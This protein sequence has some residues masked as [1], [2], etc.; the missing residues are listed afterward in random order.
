MNNKSKVIVN[1]LPQYHVIP[2]NNRWWG[3]GFTDWVAVKKSY[4]LYS[5]HYQPRIPLNGNYYSL[6]NVDTIRWQADLANEYGIYGFG[7]YHYWFSSKMQLLQKPA[8]IIRDTYDININYL[9]LW[10]N[11]SWTRTWSKKRLIND[12]A[13]D[14]DASKKDNTDDGVLAEIYYGNEKDWKIHFDYL[15]TFFK[16]RRYIKIDN[17][18]LFVFFQPHNDFPTIKKMVAYWDKLAKENG[19]NGIIC[20]TKEN[21]RKENLEYKIRYSPFSANYFFDA[22]SNKISN[23]FWSKMKHIRFSDY[24][25]A[26]EKI[27][28][29]A[30]K[31]DDKTFL[32]GFVDFDDSPRRGVKARIMKG[33]SPEKFVRYIEELLRIS[34]KQKKEY[35]FLTAWN[36]WGEGAYLEPDQNYEY[37]YLE[38]LKNAINRVEF[39]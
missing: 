19:F 24:D 17:K 36:E 1:Y 14:F 27:I 23:M 29:D 11:T 30:K 34:Q 25:K 9:F 31:A 10:D 15:L 13:P 6:D 2:E 26:W 16:D 38:E 35:V 22:L 8:E 37:A 4:P 5:G 39:I 7:I 12:W 3:D 28:K 32:S 20:L 18:P 21:W 33:G